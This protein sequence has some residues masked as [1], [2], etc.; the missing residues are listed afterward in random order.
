MLRTV[1][2]NNFVG[3]TAVELAVTPRMLSTSYLTGTRVDLRRPYVACSQKC[4]AAPFSLE[5]A[6]A[7][8]SLEFNRLRLHLQQVGCTV[9]DYQL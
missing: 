1:C 5:R 4:R 9:D 7:S 6:L 3:S 2:Y 8:I